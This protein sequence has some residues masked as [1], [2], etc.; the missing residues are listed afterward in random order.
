MS[1]NSQLVHIVVE[2]VCNPT[3]KGKTQSCQLLRD[4]HEQRTCVSYE[5][6]D[7]V[8]LGMFLQDFSKKNMKIDPLFNLATSLE[9]KFGI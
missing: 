2:S 7:P 5:F 1:T 8:G 6:L 4:R 3:E 9:N